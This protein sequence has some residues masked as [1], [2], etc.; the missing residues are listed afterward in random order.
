[1]LLRAVSM[2]LAMFKKNMQA[3]QEAS[4]WLQLEYTSPATLCFLFWLRTSVISAR[5]SI[6]R[7]K[8]HTY[9]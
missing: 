7:C 6:S 4:L 2:Y 5:A 1:M 3:P 8:Y 9:H